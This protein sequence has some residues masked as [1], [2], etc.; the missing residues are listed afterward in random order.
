MR[1]DKTENGVTLWGDNK[2]WIL[3][4]STLMDDGEITIDTKAFDIKYNTKKQRM[5]LQLKEN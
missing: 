3:D 5:V 4:A 1:L 2:K